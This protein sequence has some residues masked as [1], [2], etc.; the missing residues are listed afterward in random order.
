MV[1][2][3]RSLGE[4]WPVKSRVYWCPDLNVP[5]LGEECPGGARAFELRLTEPGDARPAT[6]HDLESLARGYEYETGGRAGLGELLGSGV[7]LV[8]KVP[9]MDAMYE[10]VS[11][12]VV[13]GRY[14]FDPQPLAWRFRFTQA[15]LLRVW[16][17]E[18]LPRLRLSGGLR[19]LLRRRVYPNSLGAP[20]RSQVVF[21]DPDGEPVGIG[22]VSDD[23]EV[24]KAHNIFRRRQAERRARSVESTWDDA[25][26]ANEYY[27]YYY[28]SR[29]IAFL[30]KMIEKVGK[31]VIVSFSG[32]K[33][34]LVALHL[35]LE[36]GYKPYLLFNDTGIELPETRE[37]VR[38]V[39]EEWG[40]EVIEA[41]A[42]DAFWRAVERV[43]PPG[44]E[45]R[46][47]CKV[48][49]LAPL[50]RVLLKRFPD[51]AVNVVGQR[52]FESLDRARSPRVWRNKWIPHILNISPI[53]EWNQLL[54]WL[55]IWKH[56]LPYNPLYDRGFERIGCFM[57]P[58]GNLAEY[59]VVREAHP[60]L[61]ARWERFLYR[62]AR[63]R[64][65]MSEEEARV[66][67][68]RG[69]WRWLTPAPQKRRLASRVGFSLGDWREAYRRWAKPSLQNFTIGDW[70]AE[71][72]LDWVNVQALEDQ[73]T[74]MGAF[75]RASRGRYELPG[76]RVRVLVEEDG[77]IR[78]EGLRGAAAREL[79]FDAVKLHYR[80][81]HCA[82]CRLCETSCPTGAIRV[83]EEDGG[84][85][86]VVDASKCIHC[87]LCLDNCP[88]ADVTV[89]RVI[90]PL[91][92]GEVTAWRRHG[93][94]TRESTVARYLKLHGIRIEDAGVA[95]VEEDA[96]TLPDA[97]SF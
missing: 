20:P 32:G 74:V 7:K 2:G 52:A 68:E 22:Y 86:P 96:L 1:P 9:F 41:S 34:S 8:N 82:G 21:V 61:W 49:K 48:T 14:Y 4:A 16:H 30:Y 70:G 78:V 54:V 91:A 19:E 73:Y 31:P 12:G 23:G 39:A 80:W 72:V 44:K 69:L 88:L 63:E 85:R 56:G 65:G 36:A 28:K 57:C 53:Q 59:N 38:R 11:E 60:E 46:W 26:K 81:L 47:C 25:V 35:T 29:A 83:V 42:G 45:Y 71:A 43:G 3:R 55:Y 66:W 15:G 10:V 18:P 95:S 76:G 64:L 92:L 51:G 94:R 87:K 5:M 79:L 67:V 27:L 17:R 62:W 50:A 37:T 97:L 24:V 40:L 58:A 77:R 93:K 84:F 75:R 90:V 6:G 33:D 89:E 13:I